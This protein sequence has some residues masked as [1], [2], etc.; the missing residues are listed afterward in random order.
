MRT[1]LL[2]GIFILLNSACGKPAVTLSES[3][4]YTKTGQT[5]L[6][7][8][9]LGSSG[10][11]PAVNSQ[12]HSPSTTKSFA[13]RYDTTIAVNA[14][15][16]DAHYRPFGLT[17]SEGVVWSNSYMEDNLKADSGIFYCKSQPTWVCDIKMDYD[18]AQ[19]EIAASATLAFTGYL[20][21]VENGKVVMTAS[22]GNR[23]RTAVGVSANGKTIY[24]AAVPE[25]YSDG[26][27]N[28]LAELMRAAGAY[29]AINLDGGGSTALIEKVNGVQQARISSTRTPPV[30]FGIRG[31]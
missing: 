20:Q 18:A 29:Q 21:L 23:A 7:S 12:A 2:F 10:V 31:L 24:I 22:N 25:G 3:L 28:K 27:L 30:S 8:I 1:S 26:N 4:T 16:F 6:W 13:S 11:S 5:H 9:D 17:I 14:S 15:Y 19:D